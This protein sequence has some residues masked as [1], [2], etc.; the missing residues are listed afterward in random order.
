MG[1]RGGGWGEVGVEV[2]GGGGGESRRI[3]QVEPDGRRWVGDG[4]K[5]R[6]VLR[7]GRQ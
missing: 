3:D 1:Q 2:G 5:M 7:G 6:G 4:S